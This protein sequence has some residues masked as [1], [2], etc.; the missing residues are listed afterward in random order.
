MDLELQTDPFSPSSANHS[1][2][3][4][5]QQCTGVFPR[6]INLLPFFLWLLSTKWVEISKKKVIT[7]EEWTKKAYKLQNKNTYRW[8]I[9]ITNNW[10]N[11]IAEKENEPRING[12]AMFILNRCLSW[13]WC[14]ITEM[15]REA[16]AIHNGGPYVYFSLSTE[17]TE[18]SPLNGSSSSEIWSTVGLSA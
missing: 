13:I 18:N 7:W 3:G 15:K 12:E 14:S 17:K 10:L 4:K 11:R 16:G 8:K 1:G 9:K 5:F 6:A 2:K